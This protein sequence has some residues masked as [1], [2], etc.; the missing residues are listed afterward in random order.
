MG[1][2]ITF[3]NR[4]GGSG[5]STLVVNLAAELGNRKKKVLIVDLDPQ[6]HATYISGINTYERKQG[7]HAVLE[8]HA[9]LSDVIIPMPY[10]LYDV[11]PLYQ[12][13]LGYNFKLDLE[14]NLNLLDSVKDKYD[15]I[16]LDTPPSIED[17]HRLSLAI[18]DEVMIPLVLN[19]LAMEGLAQLVRLI[20]LIN[21]KYNPNLKLTAIIPVN[22]NSKTNH[23]KAIQKQLE[24]SFGDKLVKFGIRTD[25][26]IQDAS[27]EQKPVLIYSPKARCVEDFS[28]LANEIAI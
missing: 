1:K 15:Y 17:I 18:S 11:V 12:K 28:D 13:D 9:T 27:W 24:E 19:F 21:E 16:L 5:K 20:Y 10:G 3:A 22:I 26:K 8:H 14:S 4:K 2:I 23:E 7:L 6:C 25:V